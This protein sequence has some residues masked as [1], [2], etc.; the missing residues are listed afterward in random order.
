MPVT[1]E[2]V[3]RSVDALAPFVLAEEWDNAGPLAGSPRLRH[4]RFGRSAH[5][6]LH[7]GLYGGTGRPPGSPDPG[8][9]GL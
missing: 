8:L 3:Y 1:V 5:P 2:E 7:P 9:P 4:R 6:R